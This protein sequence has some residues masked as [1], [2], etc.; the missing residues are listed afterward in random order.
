MAQRRIVFY[1]SS[2][3]NY[4]IFRSVHQRLK[5]DPRLDIAFTGK[6]L[7][8]KDPRKLYAQ[9]GLRDAKIIGSL[10]TRLTRFDLYLVARWRVAAPRARRKAHFFHGVSFKNYAISKHCRLYDRL[11]VVGEYHRRRFVEAGLLEPDDPRI[12][13]VGMPKTDC[14]VDGSI[15]RRAVLAGLELDPARPTVLYAPTWSEYCSLHTLGLD[16]MR[17]VARRPM[18]FLIKLH[19]A[20]YDRRHDSVDWAAAMEEFRALPNVRVLRDW[21]VCPYLVASDV[22][23]TDASSVSN[24]FALLDRPII[25]CDAPE[26][27]RHWPQHDLET[28]GR[29]IGTVVATIPE[30]DAALD[31]ALADPARQSEI[32]RACAAETFYHP[33]HATQRAVEEIYSLLELPP[34]PAQPCTRAVAAR[35]HSRPCNERPGP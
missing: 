4:I 35:G 2:P 13:R 22:L 14:L 25:F 9:V 1:G 8:A 19:D 32:R 33:G 15:D 34:P 11:F 16:L 29:K 27:F 12:A 21:D 31:D 10:R 18:N 20:S 17:A 26:L 28:W 23:I 5:A 30:L 6:M 3:M 7:A 24:E